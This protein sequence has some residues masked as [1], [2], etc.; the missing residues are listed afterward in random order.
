MLG[1][2][3]ISGTLSHGAALVAQD[4]PQAPPPETRSSLWP[5]TIVQQSG[6]LREPFCETAR[7]VSGTDYALFKRAGRADS[8]SF[9]FSRRKSLTRMSG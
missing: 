8:G 4:Q 6:S 1:V 3:W 7:Q 9:Q 2:I 5:T